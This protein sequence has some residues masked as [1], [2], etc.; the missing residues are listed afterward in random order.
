MRIAAIETFVHSQLCLVRV[1]TED[2]AFGWGQTAPYHPDI[3]ARCVHAHIVRHA[4]DHDE[5]DVEGLAERV[6]HGEYKFSGSHLWRALAGVDTALWDLRGR[7]EGRPVCALLGAAPRPLPV[8]ASSMR[9]DITPADEAARL[10]RLCGEAGF[11]AVKV[12]IGARL[13]ADADAAPGRTAALLPAV[14]AAI[15]PAVRLMVDANGA[16]TPPA[17]IALRPLLTDHEVRHFEEPC[18]FWEIEDTAAVRDAYEATTVEVAGGEQDHDL[19]QWRRILALPAVDVAQP[20][21]GYVGG[22]TRAL[23]VARRAADAGLRV[24]PHAANRSL[25]QAFTHHLM[26]ACPHAGPHME[27][28]IEPTPWLD[29]V[30]DEACTV[31][32]GCLPAPTRPGWGCTPRSSWLAQASLQRSP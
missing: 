9:R 23:Q 15:G 26:L 20:D 8:Y 18:P 4:L 29:G 2:G 5:A 16:Y 30:F 11:T 1:T 7:R 31:H 28:S 27:C 13:G 24:T 12:R 14:R 19:A 25:I 17:A 21:I 32:D 3:T 10:A 6:W 22:F